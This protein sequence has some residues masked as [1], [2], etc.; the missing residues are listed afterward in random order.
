MLRVHSG[1]GIHSFK[2]SL[3]TSLVPWLSTRRLQQTNKQK[4]VFTEDVLFHSP[5]RRV[6]ETHQDQSDLDTV[7]SPGGTPLAA[8]PGARKKGKSDKKWS[9]S[10]G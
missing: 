6:E 5:D 3:P 10:L 2:G 7:P 9:T 8:D 4:R 1:I